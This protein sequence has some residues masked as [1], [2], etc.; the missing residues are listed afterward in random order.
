MPIREA[1]RSSFYL[2]IAASGY[3]SIAHQEATREAAL[4]LR[5]SNTRS[6]QAMLKPSGAQS[7]RNASPVAPL[8][9]HRRSM[10]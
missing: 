2:P 10:R 5:R 7:P 9:P 1:A 8:L 3:M 6:S 4:G